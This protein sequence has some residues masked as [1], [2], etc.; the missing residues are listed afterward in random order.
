MKILIVQTTRMGDMLQTAPLIRMVRRKYPDAHITA[1]VRGMGRIIGE[2]HPDLDD[3][4]VYN[5]DDMFADMRARDS[6]RLLKAYRTADAVVQDL[7]ARKFDLAYNVTHSISSAMLLRLA[8]IPKVIGADIGEHGEFVLRGAW[9]NYF[10]TSVLNRDYNDLNLCDISRNFAEGAEPCRELVFDLREEDHAFAD[11]LWREEGIPD[12]AFVVCM[13]LGA[14]EKDK[15]WSARQFAELAR[16]LHAQYDAYVM[17]LGVKEEEPLAAPMGDLLGKIAF[18]LY[19]KTTVPQ[20]AAVLAKSRVLI[21]NDTGTMHL[22]AAVK[23]PIVLVSVGHVHYRE[24]GPFG[25]GHAAIEWRKERLGR[26]DMKASAE[27]ER[28]RIGAGAVLEVVEYVL[29]HAQTEPVVQL[30]ESRLL[31]EV[32]VYVTRF[33]PDGCL[34]FYPAIARPLRESD[35][36]RMAYRAMW[37]GQLSREELP[38]AHEKA[39]ARMLECFDGPPVE[40]VREWAAEYGAHFQALAA[41]ARRG[42]E[43]TVRLLETLREGKGMARAKQ[44]VGELSRVDEE[45]RIHSELH[46]ECRPLAYMARFERDN[47]EGADPF[48]LAETTLGIYEACTARAEGVASALGKAAA[49]VKNG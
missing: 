24:T 49:L 45:L 6:E 20:A 29:S 42:A 35:L 25:V 37:L 3:I 1:M 28:T 34:Q 23:C 47:L 15:R 39:L 31:A 40:T 26:S 27:E 21:T 10:F 13:Q 48:R 5:E 33:A 11:A 46:P 19:G 38:G 43:A 9:A 8:Q 41:I 17:L 14:S 2:R 18:P 4:I 16:M 22:A 7:R 36:L 32:D 44:L 12:D 30:E